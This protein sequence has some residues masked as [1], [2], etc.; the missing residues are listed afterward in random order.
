M[1][2]LDT[3]ETGNE[4]SQPKFEFTSLCIINL[5]VK[6]IANHT[7][8]SLEKGKRTTKGLLMCAT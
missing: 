3:I 7:S 6:N 8:M 5:N 2:I 4:V 1:A